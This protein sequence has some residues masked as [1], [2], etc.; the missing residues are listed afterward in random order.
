MTDFVR[1]PR[2]YYVLLLIFTN[3]LIFFSCNSPAWW[4]EFELLT[5]E[6][7]WTKIRLVYQM[8]QFKFGMND[9]QGV[10][11]L[12][13]ERRIGH[14]H[15]DMEQRKTYKVD[16]ET[17]RKIEIFLKFCSF[18]PVTGLLLVHFRIYFIGSV[19]SGPGRH[20]LKC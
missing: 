11:F 9:F 2:F 13:N 15:P 7:C 6:S 10:R 5:W 17:W 4:I 3:L 20:S 19:G 14:G 8:I 16:L 1:L 12:I 18:K